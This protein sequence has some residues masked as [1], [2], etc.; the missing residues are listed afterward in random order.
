MAASPLHVCRTY[1]VTLLHVLLLVTLGDGRN[2]RSRDELITNT[3]KGRVRGI[4]YHL[5]HPINKAVDAYLGIPF[6]TPPLD[7]LRF[8]HPQPI[9]RWEGIYNATKL[10]NSCYQGHDIFFDDFRGSTMWNPNTRVSEDCLYVNVWVPKTHPRIRKSAVMVWIYGG[11]F[12]SGT[13]TLNVYDGKILAAVNNIIVV[14]IGYRV[15]A[16][17]FLTLNTPGAPGNS[18]LFD[19]L[20]GLDWV[21]QN[22]RYF[23]GDPNNVT[24]FGES[25]GS[26][27]VS[28]HLLSPLS[29]SKF[30]RAIMQ[31]GTANMPWSTVT[32]YEG[33]RRSLELA[34]DHLHCPRDDDMEAVLRCLRGIRPQDL[35][36]EQWVARGIIQ[37]PFLPVIDGTFLTGSP[38]ESLRQRSFKK[39]PV[40]MGSNLNE[41]SFFLIYDLYEK[42]D[43]E[44]RR[45]NK[46]EF[47]ESMN[48]LFYYYPQ[49]PQTIN[50]FGMDAI[51][52]QYSNWL[53]PD[54]MDSNIANLD[55]AIGDCHFTCNVNY[56]AHE[57][58]SAGEN[59]FMYYFTHRY[60]S[61]PWP[62]WMGVLHGDE[63]LF[64]FGE[65]MKIGLNYTN[66]ERE[67]ARRMMQYWANFAKTG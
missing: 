35:V 46:D 4:R 67:L 5:P 31:S 39:C 58:A 57:Y 16:L 18:G 29:R 51:V 40:L 42:M 14:S 22:I 17:G 11:G 24:L 9:D 12:Y 1:V 23:G 7:H 47:L 25:A 33:K 38:D 34:Y 43:L 56:F 15:G 8:K 52:F 28:L 20:M 54:D 48:Q 10:P 53:D 49:Y 30:Q 3:N 45:M 65:P 36:D 19:Q 26:V 62:P 60:S 44:S 41:G 64:V 50:N 63:I 32:P 37:F 2:R 59:V 13:T 61:N 66:D 6:A 27:S 21:Q 55:N